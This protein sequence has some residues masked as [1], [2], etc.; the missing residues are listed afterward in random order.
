MKICN[1]I[2]KVLLV[3][4]LVSPILGAFG[5]FPAPT[6]DL[7]NT[8]QAFS[9]IEALSVAWYINIIIAVVFAIAIALI[10]TRR[11]ALAALLLLPVTINIVAFHGFLDG[12]L[13]TTG[14][15]MGDVLFLL[16]IYF[17][18]KNCDAYKQLWNTRS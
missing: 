4:L 16:N 12:G 14:A 3:L 9:F 6:A 8:P 2:L 5:I 1:T 10:L 15:L 13:L 7:Y 18:W 11:T 17:L